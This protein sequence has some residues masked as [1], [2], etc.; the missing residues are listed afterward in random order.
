MV[1]VPVGHSTLM[2]TVLVDNTLLVDGGIVSIHT[3][4]VEPSVSLDVSCMVDTV[5][6]V[7][8]V[9]NLGISVPNSSIVP[10]HSGISNVY[11]P[12]NSSVHVGDVVTLGS[13]IVSSISVPGSSVSMASSVVVGNLPV[14][15]TVDGEGVT[16]SSSVDVSEV[17]EALHVVQVNPALFLVLSKL[18]L[19]ILVLFT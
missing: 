5:E 18:T 19:V 2:G 6:V 10:S 9:S 7:S 1:V 17:S 12:G 3:V 16:C 11:K 8:V 14:V 13:L 15:S 4:G